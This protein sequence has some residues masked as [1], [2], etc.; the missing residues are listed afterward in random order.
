MPDKSRLDQQ[1][2]FLVE[3]DKL[4]QVFRRTWLTD[5][6]R[7]ENDAEHSWHLA[8]MVVMLRE[9]AASP[10]LD[11]LRTAKMVLIHDLVEIDAGDTFF[12]D[13]AGQSDKGAR[14]QKAAD[15]IFSLLPPDQAAE[16]R[17]LWEEFERRTTPEARYAAALD[18]L[19]PILHNYHTQGKAWQEHGVTSAMVL[20]RNRHIAEGSPAL[21]DYLLGLLE[22]AVKRGYLAP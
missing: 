13:Q 9:Y 2:E 5:K 22:D 4:K 21:W 16:I 19:Q 6:S 18:R 7:R 1:M 12:Y 17:D 10:N 15:R 3:I 14:E 11:M 8:V 20:A